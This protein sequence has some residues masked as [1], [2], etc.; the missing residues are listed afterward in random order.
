MKTSIKYERLLNILVEILANKSTSDKTIYQ[1]ENYL[2]GLK[3]NE[4]GRIKSDKDM[5]VNISKLC[6]QDTS[7]LA[8][9]L[10]N[11]INRYRESRVYY[12]EVIKPESVLREIEVILR[13]ELG[14]ETIEDEI[15]RKIKSLSVTISP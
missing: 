3:R 1:L 4:L 8:N 2:L 10:L 15:R 9:Q 11:R 13:V 6:K 14:L 12:Y 7:L 5:L